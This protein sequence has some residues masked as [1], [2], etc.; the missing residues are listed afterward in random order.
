[1]LF[2]Y[3]CSTWGIV[4]LKMHFEASITWNDVNGVILFHLPYVITLKV[5]LWSQ[6]TPQVQ[7]KHLMFDWSIYR[8]FVLNRGWKRDTLQIMIFVYVRS[9]WSI[10]ELKTRFVTWMTRNDV[11]GVSLINL[12]HLITLKAYLCSQ[13]L[14]NVLIMY[15]MF[16]WSTDYLC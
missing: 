7:I 11:N 10:V 13:N 2:V 8:L 9:S 6:G 4:E 12:S 16:G 1:M 15:F 14:P 5:Y 3:I